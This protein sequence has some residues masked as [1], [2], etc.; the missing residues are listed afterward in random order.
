LSFDAF[1]HARP[2]SDGVA[3]GELRR[4][5]LNGRSDVEAALAEYE[6]AQSAL[7]L[8]VANQYPNVTLG[9]GYI[10]D[11]GVN[12]FSLSP[13]L[14]LPVFNQNQGQIG[15]ALAKRQE[16]AAKFTA[17]QA[18]SIGA[19]DSALAAYRAATHQLATAAAL[20]A[21]ARRGA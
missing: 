11:I 19:I 16:A 10:Y 15:E 5:A 18:G 4:R 17:L 3:G 12:K 14:D 8:A 13:A 7:Q 6:A 20:L 1:E 9:P 21:G 2:L